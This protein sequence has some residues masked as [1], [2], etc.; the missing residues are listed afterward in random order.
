[1]ANYYRGELLIPKKFITP[2]VQTL[3]D[4]E[5]G[6]ND[7]VD[8]G[9]DL[10]QYADNNAPCGEFS[11][12]EKKLIRL[13]VPFDRFSES[14]LENTEETRYY[15]PG[16]NGEEDSDIVIYDFGKIFPEDIKKFYELPAAEFKVGVM[17][18]VEKNNP[19]VIS[20]VEL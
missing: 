7:S 1:M 12:L 14:C 3:L 19:S 8:L 13:R 18:L 20:L 10:V 16:K 15:R 11:T 4:A 5:F 6:S 17:S 2:E 9:D